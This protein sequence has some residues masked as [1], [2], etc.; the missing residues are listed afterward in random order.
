MERVAKGKK[1]TMMNV[2]TDGFWLVPG[3]EVMEVG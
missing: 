3:V 1:V 2:S